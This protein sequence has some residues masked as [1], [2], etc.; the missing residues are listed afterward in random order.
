MESSSNNNLY[1]T[2]GLQKT[3]TPEEIKKVKKKERENKT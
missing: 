3:A 2:L 1:Q